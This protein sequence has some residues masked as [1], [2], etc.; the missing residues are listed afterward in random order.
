MLFWASV[1]YSLIDI[2]FGFKDG[3]ADVR[4]ADS[5]QAAS[6]LCG[7]RWGSAAIAESSFAQ[8][9]DQLAAAILLTPQDPSPGHLGHIS[10]L[11][12]ECLLPIVNE[13]ASH[14]A[15]VTHGYCTLSFSSSYAGVQANFDK[16]RVPFP[17]IRLLWLSP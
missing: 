15:T 14:H 13:A 8:V 7:T 11:G 12:G 4:S 6:C 3:S 1:G 16:R 5:H 2:F 10:T 9:A 17:H